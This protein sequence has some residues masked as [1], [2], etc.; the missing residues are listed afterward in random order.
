M[1]AAHA[2]SKRANN[3]SATASAAKVVVVSGIKRVGFR[4]KIE[5][6]NIFLTGLIFFMIFVFLTAVCVMLFKG[7]CEIAVKGGWFKGD[8]FEVFRTGWKIVLKGILFRL[9]SHEIL[10]SIHNTDLTTAGAYWLSTHQHP[11]P[12][13]ADTE[14]LG[15]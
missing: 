7:F 4:A 3:P 11:E 9:V 13:R 10:D 6:T 5:T 8:T 1:R 15:R 14:G 12:L 2:L